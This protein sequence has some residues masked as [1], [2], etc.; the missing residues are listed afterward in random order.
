MIL[1]HGL[2]GGLSNWTEV[3]RYFDD[4][5][6]IYVPELPLYEKHKGDTVE[7]LV[8]F[9]ALMI[10]AAKLESVILVGNSLGGHIAIRYTHRFPNKVAKLVLTGS[11]GLYENTQVGS[12]LKRGNYSYIKE[13]V[14][15]T[16]YDPAMATDELIAE[17][18]QVT[19]DAYKCL[20]IIK[21]AKATQRDQVLTRLPDIQVPA[22]LIWGNDDRITPPAVA[23]QFR[24]NL[25]N[26]ILVMFQNCGHAPM[27]EKTDAF[28]SALEKFIQ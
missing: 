4:R 18:M 24:D 19:T 11:S 12:Y 9:L 27:M 7:Y 1:L 3:V 20:C 26:A 13:R 15:A 5:F 6:D 28:N 25:P 21:A 23:E 2:F 14:A 16:F 17:V 8:N 22:L 10:N